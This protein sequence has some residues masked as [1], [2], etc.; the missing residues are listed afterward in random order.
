MLLL[1]VSAAQLSPVKLEFDPVSVEDF[2]ELYP[3]LKCQAFVPLQQFSAATLD[4][5][6]CAE[7]KI[8]ASNAQSLSYKLDDVQVSGKQLGKS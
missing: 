1:V 7:H 5:E 6:F 8:N 2:L 3:K 4:E